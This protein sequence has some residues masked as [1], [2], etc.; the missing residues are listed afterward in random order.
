M[1]QYDCG[2][3]E[4]LPGQGNGNIGDPVCGTGPDSFGMPSI[5]CGDT[6]DAQGNLFFRRQPGNEGF[7]DAARDEDFTDIVASCHKKPD[8]GDYGAPST[9]Q[10]SC[11]SLDSWVASFLC[12][13]VNGSNC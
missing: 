3:L 13:P 2:V 9:N 8:C 12:E 7:L 10:G 11:D 6:L 1:D 4:K 5:A